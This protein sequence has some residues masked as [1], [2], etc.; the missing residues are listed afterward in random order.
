M[1]MSDVG[2]QVPLAQVGPS[3]RF[4]SLAALTKGAHEHGAQGTRLQALHLVVTPV[5]RLVRL[6][7]TV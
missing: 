6:L 1:A 5:T 2:L 7:G 3:T 4:L